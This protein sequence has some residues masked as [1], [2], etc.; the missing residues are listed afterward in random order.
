MKMNI[1]DFFIDSETNLCKDSSPAERIARMTMKKINAE[2]T[3]RKYTPRFFA[4]AAVIA[5]VLAMSIAV[6]AAWNWTGFMNTQNM[7]DQQIQEIMQTIEHSCSYETTDKEGNTHYYNSDGKEIMV[8]TPTEVKQL[9]L[10]KEKERIERCKAG[11][12]DMLDVASLELMPINITP[13]GVNEDGTFEDFLLGCGNMILLHPTGEKS[14]LLEKGDVVKVS[15]DA[16]DNC[17]VEFGAIQNGKMVET[18]S[19]KNQNHTFVYTIS[20]DGEYNF[21]LMYYSS[22]ADNFTNCSIEFQ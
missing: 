17:I 1:K 2:T 19:I 12:G 14:Y 13:V 4:I 7:S 20:E 15:M 9:E 3:G 10:A 16:T 11:A 21:S 8:L 22:D 5:I 6:Y 18:D